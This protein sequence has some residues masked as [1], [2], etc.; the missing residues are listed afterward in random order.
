MLQS[1]AVLAQSVTQLNLFKT[2]T[3]VTKLVVASQN[4]EEALTIEVKN[5]NE[6]TLFSDKCKTDQYVKFINFSKMS[7]GIY[8][9]DLTQNKGVSRKMLIKDESG[10]SIQE[11]NYYF[12]NFITFKDEDKKLLVK[13]NSNIKQSVTI[14]IMDSKG[15]V[16][17]EEKGIDTENYASRFNLSKLR[18]GNYK[19]NLISGAYSSTSNIRL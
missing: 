13:F 12:K 2:G 19:V 8:F 1:F 9:I 7:N 11:G 10:I 16:V 15:N 14:Q 3:D 6:Y 18:H 4:A 17:Y 5:A